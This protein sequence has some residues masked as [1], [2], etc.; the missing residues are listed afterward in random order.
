MTYLFYHFKRLDWLTI[1]AVFLISIFSLLLLYGMAK[2][3]S[4][5]F[6]FF[7]KQIIFFITGFIIM[8][9]I[10]FFNYRLLANSKTLVWIFLFSIL[11]LVILLFYGST[12]RGSKSW[13]I[14]GDISIQPVEFVKIIIILILAKYFSLRHI[15]SYLFHHLL[16]SFFYVLLP[17]VLVLLQPDLG[18]AM[19]ILAIWFG[20]IIFVGI[21][22]KTLIMLL[23]FFSIILVLSWQYFLAPYQK[24]RFLSFFDPNYNPFSSGYNLIQSKIAIGSGG[25]LGVGLG[26]G[27]QTQF[28]FLPEPHTD[29]ILATLGEEL[30]L[31]GIGIFFLIFGVFISRLLNLAIKINDNFA[32][33]FLF[34]FS[35]LIFSQFF[36]NTA[37]VV[38]VF[39]I[40]GI[41]LPFLSYGGSSIIS[42]FVGLGITQAIFV[43][44]NFI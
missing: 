23:L 33:L 9:L 22:L 5:F 7:E 20:F 10:S 6:P 15:E 42:L 28:R 44:A 35:F 17:I 3:N 24:D 1:G 13:F 11:I 16:I 21:R 2:N 18:S 26:Q 38:G 29:F 12:I 41:S 27:T 40:I 31:L 25:I 43:K 36:I 4:Q 34:G 32:K 39:P 14:I 19:T 30:G 8:L 37:M